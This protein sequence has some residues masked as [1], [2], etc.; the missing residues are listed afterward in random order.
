VVD[1]CLI[2]EVSFNLDKLKA[3]VKEVLDRKG[4]AVVCVAEGAGQVGGLIVAQ[5]GHTHL[6]L[7]A[8][9]I[10]EC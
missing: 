5:E 6:G 2:P 4:H 7:P 1:V 10:L 3:Y 8:V 9:L